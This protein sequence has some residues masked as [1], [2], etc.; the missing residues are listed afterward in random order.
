MLRSVFEAELCGRHRHRGGAYDCTV[1]S[2]PGQLNERP[3]LCLSVC[4]SV[5]L[6][7][8]LLVCVAY[9]HRI[10]IEIDFVL[11]SLKFYVHKVYF[12]LP[13][14]VLVVVSV[15]VVLVPDHVL[16]LNLKVHFIVIIF[17]LRLSKKTNKKSLK[18]NNYTSWLRLRQFFLESRNKYEKILLSK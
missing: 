3:S 16:I 15:V 8:C 6:S 18:A 1:V 11:C 4:P 9:G 12:D 5:S 17:F 14:V 7:A 13:V 10:S 2:T